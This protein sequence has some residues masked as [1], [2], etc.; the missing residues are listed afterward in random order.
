MRYVY[1]LSLALTINKIITIPSVKPDKAS[2]VPERCKT[3]CNSEYGLEIGINSNTFAFSNCNEYCRNYD[4]VFIY[5]KDTGLDYDIYCGLRWQCVEYARRWLI[6]NR[7]V[8]FPNV[9]FAY[10]IFQMEYVLDVISGIKYKF[11]SYKNENPIPPAVGDLIIYPADEHCI[12]GHVAVATGV[13]LTEGYVEVSEQNY[14]NVLWQ[15][16]ESYARRI[17]L[18]KINELYYLTNIHYIGID[19]KFNEPGQGK[20]NINIIG[21]K[22]VVK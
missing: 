16:P 7:D 3:K 22:R 14:E 13:N 12:T 5:K 1:F 4:P 20:E 8:T 21:W 2:S 9:K 18:K 19:Y 6:I 10:N 11:E 15:N 17:I